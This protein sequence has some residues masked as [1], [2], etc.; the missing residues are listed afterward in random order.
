MAAKNKN[1]GVWPVMLT[2]FTKD[3]SI[4]W[5]GLD[6]LIDWYLA[7]DITGLFAV[8]GSSEMFDLNVNERISLADYTLQSVSNKVPVIVSG[9]FGDSLDEQ[10]ELIKIMD[11]LGAEAVIC[12]VNQFAKENGPSNS[13]KMNVEYVLKQ[14]DNIKLGLYECPLPYHRLLSIE[15]TKWAAETGR[16]VWMKETSEN[17]KI[18]SQKVHAAQNSLLKILNADARFLLESLNDGGAGYCGI[19]TNFFPNLLSWMC[20]HY[21][22]QNN[23]VNALQ[24]F[25]NKNQPIIDHK[26]L[27]N[28]KVFLQISGLDILT[29]CRVNSF[30]F[31]DLE[32]NDLNHLRKN[33]KQMEL[34]LN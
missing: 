20:L 12:L 6:Q 18:F 15:E 25:F 22:D 32:Y 23:Y 1:E 28:G 31:S 33:I 8:C 17:P 5:S 30:D 7:A 14:T 21:N 13:W 19:A 11:G 24:D 3:N 34:A 4:D 16:F 10:I 9:V 27:Q 29:D 2:P 26:Y